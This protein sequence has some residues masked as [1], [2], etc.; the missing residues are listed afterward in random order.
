MI[1]GYSMQN[2]DFSRQLQRLAEERC[3]RRHCCYYCMHINRLMIAV[4]ALLQWLGCSLLFFSALFCVL[5][6]LCV[7]R[8]VDGVVC[9]LWPPVLP[10]FTGI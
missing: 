9:C 2:I 6:V 4:S 3:V 5:G 10:C 8:V 1:Q 7:D